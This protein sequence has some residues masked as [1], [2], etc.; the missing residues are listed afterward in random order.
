[1]QFTSIDVEFTD[2][3]FHRNFSINDDFNVS[4]ACLNYSGLFIASKGE[5]MQDLDNYEEDEQIDKDEEKLPDDQKIEKKRS[6]VFFKP[7]NEW[8]QLKD[9]HFK[10]DQGEYVD[11]IAQGTDWCACLTDQC[12]LRFFT[13]SGV[14]K[15]VLYQNSN[16]ITMAGYENLLA[17]V[18]H[19]GL[20]IFGQQNIC[21]KIIDCSDQFKCIYD[22]QFPV[23]NGSQLKWVG[24][25]EE[26]MLTSLDDHG[27]LTGFDFQMK[28]FVPLLDLK[29][30]Y[31]ITFK[32]IWVV[33]ISDNELLVIELPTDHSQP[34]LKMKSLYK[35]IALQ[36]PLIGLAN[37]KKGDIPHQDEKF[38]MSQLAVNH[39]QYRK[40]VWEPLKN[41]R[42]RY[43][44]AK[45]LSDSILEAKEI[46]QKKKELDKLTLNLIKTCIVEGHDD[47]VYSYIDNLC[48]K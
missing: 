39:E 29:V 44:S 3:N 9:W 21:C 16:V 47:K 32:Q 5:R 2:R 42:G 12:H 27:I 7:C 41:F 20:P 15:Q 35:K 45:I 38:M 22:G 46:T 6:Y 17:I 8:K 48:F 30:R 4:M 26:G 14:Q 37:G 24:F 1:M 40:D 43:E 10:L 31:P 11:L 33:G 28:Q 25:S 13:Q 19:G 34:H 18:Y 36:I 23:T